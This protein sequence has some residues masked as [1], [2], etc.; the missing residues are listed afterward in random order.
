VV[1]L[2]LVAFVVANHRRPH[3]PSAAADRPTEARHPR[4]DR[5][6]PKTS[7]Q[8]PGLHEI[9]LWR[10]W[11]SRTQSREVAEVSDAGFVAG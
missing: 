9:Q 2:V 6:D 8:H 10:S 11:N 7:V 4:P 5:T 3:R 1:V